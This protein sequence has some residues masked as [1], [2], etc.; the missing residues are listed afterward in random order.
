MKLGIA[1]AG[2]GARGAAHLGMLQVFEENGIKVD[3]YTGSSA[4][5]IVAAAK[6]FGYSNKLTMQILDS[7]GKELIDINLWGIISSIPRKFANIES[8]LK[9]RQLQ[10]F[11]TKNFNHQIGTAKYPLG[12][13]ST[14]L[15]TGAQII[16]SSQDI[17]VEKGLDSLIKV[18]GGTVD[19]SLD[20]ILYSS[21]AVPG[22]FPPLHYKNHKLV[23][24]SV[25]NSLPANVLSAMGADKIIAI[26]LG[27]RHDEEVQGLFEV[28]SSSLSI[29]IDQN[30]D[31]S[32]YYVKD[33]MYLGIDLEG[34]GLFDFDKSK[35]AYAK[36]YEYGKK[37]VNKVYDFVYEDA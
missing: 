18:Y 26:G 24:G 17:A 35:E 23:D 4:G 28:L 34:I 2:G 22:F 12:I 30:V 21:A 11:L 5:S 13:V 6:A 3:M 1:L 8:L 16:F 29:M 33:Y 7:V 25:V 14:D 15:I 31:Y 19:L 10:K 9:G 27:V 32:L 20:N 37:V 36:G